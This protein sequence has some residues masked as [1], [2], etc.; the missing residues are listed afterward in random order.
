[1]AKGIISAKYLYD[2]AEAIRVKSGSQS[3]ITPAQMAAAIAE[4]DGTLSG[5]ITP[6]TS[7]DKGIITSSIMTGI[8]D[9]IRAKL[10]V[11]TQYSPSQMADAI[12]AIQAAGPTIVPW[13]TGTD[14]EVGAM[15]D[16][17]HAG[18]IDLQQDGGWAVGDVRTISISA[19]TGG[20]GVNIAA[21]DIDIVITSFDE[22]MECG[23]IL[24]FDF[25]D[26]LA[27]NT[28]MNQ[29]G[30]SAGGYG[31]SIMKTTTIPALVDAL[32]DWLK[33]RLLEFSVLACSGGT[34]TTI[35]TVTGNKLALRSEIEVTGTTSYSAAGEGSQIGYYATAN[36][37]KK[38]RGHTGAND[39][40]WTR[41]SSPNANRSFCQINS[42][43][44]ATY[45]QAN[46][47]G[48]IAPFGCL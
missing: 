3:T 24:Q 31:S 13:S 38:K 17:A 32:P 29:A 5:S 18:T 44:S 22:Y 16:A 35:N 1:M 34:S 8:A 2:I 40:W 41:S 28:F 46:Y 20:G 23:N 33:S 47:G 7:T 39:A 11:Q 25:K 42:G 37:R 10:D 48:T 12:L 19:F 26:A 21:Q 27:I 36:N 30:S 15:I 43:G 14:A 6:S 4:I 45:N 9:A